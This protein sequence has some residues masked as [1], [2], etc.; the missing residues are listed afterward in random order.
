[1]F[2]EKYIVSHFLDRCFLILSLEEINHFV[3]VKKFIEGNCPED[4]K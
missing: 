2:F 3:L 1:V 4:N